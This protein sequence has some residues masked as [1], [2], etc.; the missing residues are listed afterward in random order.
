MTKKQTEAFEA[1]L[2][3]LRDAGVLTGFEAENALRRLKNQN[4]RGS[5]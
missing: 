4:G 1:L 2:E 5:N 3:L